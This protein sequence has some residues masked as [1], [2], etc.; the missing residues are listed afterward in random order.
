MSK[1]LLTVTKS[2]SPAGRVHVATREVYVESEGIVLEPIDGNTRTYV[3]T[4][5]GYQYEIDAEVAEVAAAIAG[6]EDFSQYT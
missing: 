5:E 1:L 2:I 3:I 4:K 6:V